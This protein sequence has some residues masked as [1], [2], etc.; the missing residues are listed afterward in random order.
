VLVLDVAGEAVAIREALQA[1]IHVMSW[2]WIR[3]LHKDDNRFDSWHHALDSDLTLLA[4]EVQPNDGPGN[5]CVH[6]QIITINMII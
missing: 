1:R 4:L 5:L 3:D 6:L 2:D